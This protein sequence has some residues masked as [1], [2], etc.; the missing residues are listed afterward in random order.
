[1]ISSNQLVAASSDKN[2][3]KIHLGSSRDVE[4]NARKIDLPTRL[5]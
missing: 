2:E 4:M 5:R 1:M 3:S